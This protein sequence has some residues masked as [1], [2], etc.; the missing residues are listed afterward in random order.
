MSTAK[1][2][3]SVRTAPDTRVADTASC[4]WT[5]AVT[6]EPSLGADAPQDQGGCAG[7]EAAGQAG[8][9]DLGLWHL[10]LIHGVHA[11]GV[12]V[13]ERG[14]PGR[15]LAS[16][17]YCSPM[18]PSSTRNVM[19]YKFPNLFREQPPSHLLTRG[20]LSH[21]HCAGLGLPKTN[22]SCFAGE[23]KKSASQKFK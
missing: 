19:W 5:G 21:F 2:L 20:H 3:S 9:G 7:A 13:T 16:D 18:S 22:E 23:L 10:S 14:G 1:F 4:A 12:T 15:L 11:A 17:V 6:R 8:P